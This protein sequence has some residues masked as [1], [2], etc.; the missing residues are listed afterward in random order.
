MKHQT[1][2]SKKKLMKFVTDHYKIY[3]SLKT[4]LIFSINDVFVKY[5][6]YDSYYLYANSRVFSIEKI[7]KSDV[8]MNDLAI[9]RI[10]VEIKTL[11]LHV[12]WTVDF[13]VKSIIRITRVSLDYVVKVWMNAENINVNKYVAE[14]KESE[15]YYIWWRFI[16]LLCEKKSLD[17]DIWKVRFNYEKLKDALNWKKNYKCIIQRESSEKS[18]NW[19]QSWLSLQFDATRD[20][21]IH[22][23]LS[24]SFVDRRFDY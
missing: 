3:N 9:S 13:D 11:I 23:V 21:L 10:I 1:R 24:S 22:C 4:S 15:W 12:N 18:I 17:A 5:V 16:H 7:L 6:D 14:K 19:L 8:W 20:V 2:S